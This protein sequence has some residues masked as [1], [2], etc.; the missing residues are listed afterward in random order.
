MSG[1]VEGPGSGAGAAGSVALDHMRIDKK[2][3][4]GKMRFVLLKSIGQAFITGDY[5]EQALDATRQAHFA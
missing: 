1:R 3:K 5:P 4:A 2:V